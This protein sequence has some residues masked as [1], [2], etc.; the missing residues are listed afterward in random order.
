LAK[1]E[2]SR[3]LEVFDAGVIRQNA[4]MFAEHEARLRQ[5]LAA[6]ILPA[7][8]MCL[9]PPV[10]AKAI[11]RKSASDAA[12]YLCWS[13]PQPRFAEECVLV[14]CRDRPAPAIDP[15]TATVYLREWIDRARYEE[16]SGS[17]PVRVNPQ[18]QRGYAVVWAVVNLGFDTFFS[19]PVVLG[20]VSEF[21]AGGDHSQRGRFF[22]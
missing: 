2:Q 10:G 13:W 20:G 18:W 12:V 4:A 9:G 19:E 8:K 5:W 7:T 21:R 16:G 14:I 17:F 3:F 15:R 1:N 22:S 6:E 11:E